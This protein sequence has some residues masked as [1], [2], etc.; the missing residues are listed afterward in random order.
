M[1][2]RHVSK[3][4]LISNPQAG[5]RKTFYACALLVRPRA[6]GFP[7]QIDHLLLQVPSASSVIACL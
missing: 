4:P 1:Q 5:D 7:K 2:H 6:H 3:L